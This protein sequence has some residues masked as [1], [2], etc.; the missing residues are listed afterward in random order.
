MMRGNFRR[1]NDRHSPERPVASCAVARC[2]RRGRVAGFAF[3]AVALLGS[4]GCDWFGAAK[5]PPLPG[6]RIAVLLHQR[7]LTPD[8]GASRAEIVLPEPLPNADWPQAGGY[9]NHAMQHMLINERIQLAW[10]A[11]AGAGAGK[12]AKIVGSPIVAAG[13]V[14]VMDA[15]TNVSAFDVET[16]RRLWKTA[17]TPK[18]DDDGHIGGGVAFEHDR[19]FATT[20]FAQVVALD[21][22]S[23]AV[24]W[25]QTVAGPLR[26]QPTVRGGRVFAVTV[27]NKIIVLNAQDGRTLWTHAAIAEVASMLGGASPAIDG[28]VAVVPYSS[29]ELVAYRVETGQV[30]WTESL[31]SVRGADAISTL[32]H[33]RGRPVIDRGR[34]FAMSHGGIMAAIDLRTGQRL[35][36]R[37]VG[38]L[39]SPWVAGDFVYVLTADAEIAC[40][41]R[42]DGRILW[43]RGLPR[44]ED[45]KKRT[46]PIVWT[47]PVLASDRLLIAGSHGEAWSLSPYTGTLLGKVKLP[48]GVSVPPVVAGGS[49]YFLADNAKLVAFR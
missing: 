40:L 38:G 19:V 43:V 7:T 34:V 23:G 16:G 10:R 17:L 39:D 8:P 26:T 37:D 42:N 24:L 25:R 44:Y 31:A 21:A 41:A 29:G 28:D 35:W 14:Y 4:V 18:D 3:A 5:Q 20:G 9:P 2:R 6:E 15:E 45:E 30:L 47:G 33:I 1:A 46:D 36:D 11:D 13:R 27:D 32:S 49:V 22:G 12:E 48:S